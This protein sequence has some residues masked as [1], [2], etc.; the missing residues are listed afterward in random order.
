V[1]RSA[2]EVAVDTEGDSLHHYPARLSLIQAG[3]RDGRVWL[4]DP[5]ALTDLRAL[6]EVF[7]DP[8]VC[9]V[10]H[11]GDN[12]L[13][14]LKQRYDFTVAA[15]F[16][17]AIAARFLGNVALGLDSL[18]AQYLAQTLPPSR[19]KDD[20]SARPLTEAQVAYAAADVRHLFALKDRLADELARMG[21]L[22]W[23]FEECAALAAQPPVERIE[24]PHAYLAVRGAHELPPPD[25]AVLRELHA[26]REQLALAADRPPFKILSEDILLGIVRARPTDEAALARVPGVTP[27]VRQRWGGPLLAAV[28][29][30]SSLD[31]SAWPRIER[32]PRPAT[33]PAVSRRIER[34]R[35]WRASATAR[36]GLPPG[37]LLPNRM[38]GAIAAAGPRSTDELAAVSGVRRWRVEAFGREIVAA[39]GAS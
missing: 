17:T 27:R 10:L 24:D 4:I 33:A 25:L 29:R 32:R 5:L 26:L 15:M 19:Q 37:V 21:R 31:E 35:K 13:I 20:W 2:R 6:G 22:Q 14:H 11:A 34:L 28:A 39:L 3:I 23:V 9:L 8:R 1:L 12:D 16:D 7:S 18:L 38:I 30:G 36:V